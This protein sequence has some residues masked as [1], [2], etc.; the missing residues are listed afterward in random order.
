MK[1]KVFFI[2][3]IILLII[4]VTISVWATSRRGSS[5]SEVRQIQEKLKRW[6]YYSGS[7]DGIYGS[8][9]EKAVKKFQKANGLQ[10]RLL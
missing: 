2:L 5:G 4:S 6:G 9:T 1:R 3:T 10:E 8:G 7:V